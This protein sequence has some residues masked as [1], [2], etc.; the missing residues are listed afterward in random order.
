MPELGTYGSVRGAAGNSR[1]Y[2]ECRRCTSGAAYTG[3]RRTKTSKGGNRDEGTAGVRLAL[4]GFEGSGRGVCDA[5]TRSQALLDGVAAGE[6][7]AVGEISSV[8][9]LRSSALRSA[10]GI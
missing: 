7:G 5:G 1:S 6:Q 8:E 4:W 9:P 3:G 10:L 2:R